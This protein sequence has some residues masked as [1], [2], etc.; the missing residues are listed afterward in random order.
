MTFKLGEKVR[1]KELVGE[2]IFIDE[3]DECYPYLVGIKGY[4]GQTLHDPALHALSIEKGYEH[5]CQW[6][7]SEEIEAVEKPLKPIVHPVYGYLC[8][9]VRVMRS[10]VQLTIGTLL[11]ALIAGKSL[12][13]MI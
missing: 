11:I 2:I 6:F 10:F 5:Q 3:T 13:G 4:Q 8:L 1:R 12:I 7:M 9:Y